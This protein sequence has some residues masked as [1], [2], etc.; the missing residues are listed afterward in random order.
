[1]RAAS[2]PGGSVEL[3]IARVDY[4]NEERQFMGDCVTVETADNE[5][6]AELI[7]QRLE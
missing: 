7:K 5:A 2:P 3:T 1:V 6:I 4:T